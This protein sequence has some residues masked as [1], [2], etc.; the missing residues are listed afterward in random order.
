M[1]KYYSWD[2]VHGQVASIARQLNRQKWH[3]DYIVGITRGGLVPATML[4]YYLETP[5]HTLDVEDKESNCWMSEDAFGYLPEDGEDS[6]VRSPSKS[7]WTLRKKILIVDNINRYGT[8]IAWIKQDWQNSCFPND[9]A[10][11]NI[12]KTNV[13]FAVLADYVSSPQ[14][15]QYSAETINDER[16]IVYPWEEWWYNR[17]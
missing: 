3:P 11:E 2:D 5:M 13:K 12:W 8:S 7:D 14:Y 9:P 17:K 10:W 1:I 4:S 15:V 16:Y 6:V